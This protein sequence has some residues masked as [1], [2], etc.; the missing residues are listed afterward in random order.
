MSPVSLATFG[1]TNELVIAG[2]RN[3][4]QKKMRLFDLSPTTL[5]AAIG[6]ATGL[7]VAPEL[8]VQLLGV[9]EPEARALYERC[10]QD[11]RRG[12]R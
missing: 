11:R 3:Y 6:A 4:P 8:R 7:C 9:A 5:F 10:E 12:P 2:Q 1:A